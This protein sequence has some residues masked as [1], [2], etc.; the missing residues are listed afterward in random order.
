MALEKRNGQV[1]IVWNDGGTSVKGLA[2]H[3]HLY[4]TEGQFVKTVVE[5]LTAVN[6][7]TITDLAAQFSALVVAERD[8]LLTE[9]AALNVQIGDLTTERDGL[10]AD[11]ATLTTELAKASSARDALATDKDTLTAERDGL[12]TDKQMLTSQVAELASELNQL[13]NP[14]ANSRHIAPFDFLSLFTAAELY[15]VLTSVDP[16]VIVG[17]AKLQ[18]IITFVDLDFADT[19]QLVNYLEAIGLIAT[20]RAAQILAGVTPA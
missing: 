4:T 11:R 19:V 6:D 16:T 2:V 3:S 14:P 9:R 15:A 7:P 18:T 1:E 20:G 17:R 8:A 5:P 12:A 10:V 13:K